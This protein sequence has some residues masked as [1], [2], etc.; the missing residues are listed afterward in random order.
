MSKTLS[1]RRLDRIHLSVG[2]EVVELYFSDPSSLAEIVDYPDQLR[3]LID[4]TLTVHPRAKEV[5]QSAQPRTKAC[6]QRLEHEVRCAG[7]EGIDLARAQ[8]LIKYHLDR[9][10][11]IKAIKDMIRRT[12]A[13]HD[14]TVWHGYIRLRGPILAE[15]INDR[16][17]AKLRQ[18]SLAE[19]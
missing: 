11:T 5:G 2:R 6:I 1:Q 13:M 19:I 7:W 10:L 14:L 15:Q 16:Y 18:E 12:R 17:Q 3:H 4:Q 9:D 8:A